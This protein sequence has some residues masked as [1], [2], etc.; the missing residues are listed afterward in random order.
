MKITTNSWMLPDFMTMDTYST[1]V[2][3]EMFDIDYEAE[4]LWIDSDDIDIDF[5]NFKLDLANK[6]IDWVCKD[7]NE[8]LPKWMQFKKP[9]EIKV[10]SPKY[11]NYST[12]TYNIDIEFNKKEL[13]KFIKENEK[14]LNKHLEKFASYDGFSSFTPS[15][16]GALMKCEDIERV[17]CCVIDFMLKDTEHEPRSE[18]DELYLCSFENLIYPEK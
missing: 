7:I 12:D 10:V 15:S 14:E 1:Y 5:D 8:D 9:N 3:H 16:Y 17:V 2:W 18:I 6:I 11:Y 13:Y 4:E